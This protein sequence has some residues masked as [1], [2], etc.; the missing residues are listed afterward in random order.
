MG[1]PLKDLRDEATGTMTQLPVNPKYLNLLKEFGADENPHSNATLLDHLVG[2][3]SLLANWGNEESVSVGG[4]FHSIYGTQ[5][6]KIQSADLA[7]R[8]AIANVIGNEAEL[9]AYLFCVCDRR[10]FY[11]EIGKDK[12]MLWNCVSDHFEPSAP[13]LVRA[14]VEIEAANIVEQTDAAVPIP[15]ASLSIIR[16]AYARTEPYLSRG[17]SAAF[18]HLLERLVVAKHA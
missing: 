8:P 16:Q 6:Y 10:S 18:G 4:L 5:S 7:C 9:L 1:V 12:P 14:L 17:G 13:K 2:T 11:A 15:R 3:Y